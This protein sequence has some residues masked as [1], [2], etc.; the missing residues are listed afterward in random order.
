MRGEQLLGKLA[1]R[2]AA[3]RLHKGCSRLLSIGLAPEA[4]G[5][6]DRTDAGGRQPPHR[7]VHAVGFIDHQRHDRLLHDP[8]V[9]PQIR[10]GE[11]EH[12]QPEDADPAEIEGAPQ[13][14]REPGEPLLVAPADP[15]PQRD[16]E[17]KPPPP[18]PRTGPVP[19]DRVDPG[20]QFM[21]H[22]GGPRQAGEEVVHWGMSR[23]RLR[24]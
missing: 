24:K 7:E 13:P 4:D 9:E 17:Q 14:R 5:A 15:P 2:E 22:P 10:P 11:H 6:G 19:F 18:D 12:E 1:A 23:P 16:E 8:L 20:G 21:A 3:D